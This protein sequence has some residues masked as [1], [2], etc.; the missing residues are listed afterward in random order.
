MERCGG[1]FWS[2]QQFGA[3]WVMADA[4]PI[5]NVIFTNINITDSTFSGIMLKSETYKPAVCEM[6]VVFENVSVVKSGTQGILVQDA[7]GT[8]I[9]RNTRLLESSGKSVL[10]NKDTNGKKGTGTIKFITDDKCAGLVE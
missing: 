9:F 5:T 8:A 3:L 6:N 4:S 10:R 2:G 7:I 1:S